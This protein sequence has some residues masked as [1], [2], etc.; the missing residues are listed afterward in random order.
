MTAEGKVFRFVH[1]THSAAAQLA[2]QPVVRN[3]LADIYDWGGHGAPPL[4][5]TAD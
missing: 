3:R 4:R 2:Q 5:G 1:H